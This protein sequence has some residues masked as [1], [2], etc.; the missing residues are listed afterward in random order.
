MNSLE[1]KQLKRFA[2]RIGLFAEIMEMPSFETYIKPSFYTDTHE[3]QTLVWGPY[4][5]INI[6]GCDYDNYDKAH[7]IILMENVLIEMEKHDGTKNK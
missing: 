1:A 3:T 4:W 5:T 6:N 7:K 2:D